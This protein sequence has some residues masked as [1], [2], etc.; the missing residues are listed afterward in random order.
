M[1]IRITRIRSKDWQSLIYKLLENVYNFRRTYLLTEGDMIKTTPF[2]MV[3]IIY[4]I[5]INTN[6]TPIPMS[7]TGTLT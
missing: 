7:V 2:E 3:F 4:Y 1:E 5:C 6:F